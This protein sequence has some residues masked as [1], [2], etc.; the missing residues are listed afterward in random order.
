MKEHSFAVFSVTEQTFAVIF[1]ERIFFRG[2]S[3]IRERTLPDKQTA[4]E[5]FRERKNRE[6][7][8]W[9]VCRDGAGREFFGPG[10]PMYF[11]NDFQIFGA[12][13]EYLV[14]MYDVRN[15]STTNFS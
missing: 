12:Y 15:I 6:R 10:G 1:R 8:G 5:D 2:F 13:I 9:T 3:K 4:K 14:C 7:A 11:V